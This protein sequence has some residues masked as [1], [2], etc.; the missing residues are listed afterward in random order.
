MWFNRHAKEW[1]IRVLPELRIQVSATRFRIAD[2]CLLDRNLPIEQIPK[3]HLP[4][5]VIE[6]LSPE[7]RMSKYQRRLEDCRQAGISHLWVINP[8]TKTGYDCSTGSWIET[9]HFQ[10]AGTPI[11]LDLPALFKTLE[12]ERT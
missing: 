9:A 10:I 6:I 12:E 11:E 7:D 8:E 3:E 1:G 2:V 4:M 5:A